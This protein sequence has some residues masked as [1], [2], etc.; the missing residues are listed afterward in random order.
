V[1]YLLDTCII[2]EV[3]KREPHPEVLKWL[4]RQAEQN[5][6]LSSLTIGELT[7]GIGRMPASARR[8][9][10]RAWVTQTLPV[11]FKGQILNIDSDTAA[12]WGA[13]LA[14]AE[15]RGEALPIVDSLMAATAAFHDLTVASRNEEDF[16]RCRVPVFN[17]WSGGDSP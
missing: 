10:L 11:R 17:P 15:K 8:D 16:H 12:R 14:E 3:W 1:N 4:E 9:R 5:L 6:F 2:S 7:K 13:M